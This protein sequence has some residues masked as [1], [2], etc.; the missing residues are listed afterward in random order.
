M[1]EKLQFEQL[2]LSNE[3]QKEVE[4]KKKLQLKLDGGAVNEQAEPVDAQN[5]APEA[6]K[7]KNRILTD[8]VKAWE[9]KHSVYQL[10]ALA[11]VSQRCE[12]C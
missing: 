6:I 1:L 3:Y 11:V 9:V 2:K 12:V 8:Q 4:E 10:F 5:E 7:E